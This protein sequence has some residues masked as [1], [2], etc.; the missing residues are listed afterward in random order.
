MD[1]GPA[2]AHFPDGPS[3]FIDA[4]PATG[5]AGRKQEAGL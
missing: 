1:C 4:A 5:T 3:I 2:E